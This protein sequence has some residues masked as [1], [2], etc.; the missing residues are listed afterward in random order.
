[1]D[2]ADRTMEASGKT[3]G[4]QC[5]PGWRA[6]NRSAKQISTKVIKAT[7]VSGSP[8]ERRSGKPCLTRR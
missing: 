2:E 5:V 7:G 1:M 6:W 4:C 8:Q 3:H